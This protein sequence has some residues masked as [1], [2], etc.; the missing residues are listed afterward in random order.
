MFPQA[1][2][3]LFLIWCM[4]T[5]AVKV[6][7][8]VILQ[9]IPHVHAYEASVPISYKTNFPMAQMTLLQA[10][11]V[12]QPRCPLHSDCSIEKVIEQLYNSIN[13]II[14]H[15]HQKTSKMSRTTRSIDA[16]G[17][18]L[19]FCCGTA[20]DGELH[21]LEFNEQ[22]ITDHLNAFQSLVKDDH[23]DLIK[24]TGELNLFTNNISNQF[25]AA[26]KL[27]KKSQVAADE[28]LY[29]QM[30]A[31]AFHIYSHLY[32]IA[33]R[34]FITSIKE[35]CQQK[36]IP[37]NVIKPEL[38]LKDLSQ[39]QEK[40]NSTTN[41]QLAVDLKNYQQLYQLPI[42]TCRVTEEDVTI[43]V[44]IPIVT[45]ASNFTLFK[46]IP[47]PLSWKNQS[48][49][50]PREDMIIAKSG[51][52][53]QV[54]A[55]KQLE[56]CQV[57]KTKLCYLPRQQHSGELSSKCTEHLVMSSTL[58]QLQEFCVFTCTSNTDAV[59]ILEMSPT[60]FYV[61]NI[62]PGTSIKCEGGEEQLLSTTLPG[63]IQTSIPCNCELQEKNKTLI[64][65]TFPCDSRAPLIPNIQ[66]FLPLHWLNIKSLK[67]DSFQPH[68]NPHFDN[69][70]DILKDDWNV[71]IPTLFIHNNIAPDL[72]EKVTLPNSWYDI[73]NSTSMAFYFIYAW[74]AL[75]TL[76][77][78]YF[79]NKIHMLLTLK[80]AQ[81]KPTIHMMELKD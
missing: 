51:N 13:E 4:E 6:F 56:L 74:L 26:Y 67:V 19:H 46:Y 18:F 29:T 75:I 40:M 38:L 77:L 25:H 44:K 59:Q 65:K 1:L 27:F 31:Y 15:D 66:H 2:P 12:F 79:I 7:S 3:L 80:K 69:F 71:T 47:T 21:G 78:L 61:T 68:R 17:D 33:R 52:T 53:I 14:K 32:L 70:T 55:G 64:R 62:Q 39:L 41:Q 8:G 10:D 20:T 72:F 16:I 58:Q 60:V 76:A 28:E 34:N 22:H 37:A 23:Q 11:K 5:A 50:L 81:E 54:L 57:P 24:V 73:F 43:T 48:C 49:W 45:K 30:I 36:L 35:T 9:P 63:T 42:T